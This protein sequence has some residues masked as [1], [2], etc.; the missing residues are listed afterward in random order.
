MNTVPASCQLGWLGREVRLA[1]ERG[2]PGWGEAG[3]RKEKAR[4]RPDQ[5]EKHKR[6]NK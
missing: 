4:R 6:H 2:K 5:I 1:Q 3:T